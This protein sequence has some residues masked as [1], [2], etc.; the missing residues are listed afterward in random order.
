[1]S[2]MTAPARRSAMAAYAAA[3]GDE[4]PQPGRMGG[5]DSERLQRRRDR[6]IAAAA[7]AGW[8]LALR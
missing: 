7:E 2:T 4:S 6:R 3:T 1:M 5:A 8:L